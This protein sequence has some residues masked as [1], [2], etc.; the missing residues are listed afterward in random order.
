MEERHGDS[1]HNIFSVGAEV[2]VIRQYLGIWVILA[3]GSGIFEVF[4][5]R[6]S[7]LKPVTCQR[8]KS[9]DIKVC[10]L[11]LSKIIRG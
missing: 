6:F 5:K 1:A 11:R 2:E 7:W 3:L 4:F 10:I 9:L 8:L